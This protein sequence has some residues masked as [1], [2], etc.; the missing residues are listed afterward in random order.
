MDF[1]YTRAEMTTTKTETVV[2]E[3]VD[4]LVSL[5]EAD[6]ARRVQG[7]IV[8]AF[9]VPRA[10]PASKPGPRAS[11]AATH[12]ARRPITVTPKLRKARK[13]QAKYM[14]ALRALKAAD[15]VRVKKLAGEEGAAAGLKLALSLK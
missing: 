6:V 11:K 3:F 14:V 8:S 5:V 1:R 12:P 10:A 2:R 13:L 4:R 15:R 7:A 9:L